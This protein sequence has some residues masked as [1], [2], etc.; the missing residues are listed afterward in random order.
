L[1]KLRCDDIK[2]VK[3]WVIYPGAEAYPVDDDIQ[4][5]PMHTAM[6]ALADGCGIEMAS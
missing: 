1:A 3:K 2:P 5:M 6:Q 4:V